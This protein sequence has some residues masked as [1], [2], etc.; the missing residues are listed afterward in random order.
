MHLEV[1]KV[2]LGVHKVHLEV[3]KVLESSESRERER[4]T[5]NKRDER[6]PPVPALASQ[7][8][9]QNQHMS[10]WRERSTGAAGIPMPP[11]CSDG[12]QADT[13]AWRCRTLPTDCSSLSQNHHSTERRAISN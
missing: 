1:H 13:T 7:P 5:S 9:K 11:A 12:P 8:R 3:H 4:T 6:P 10:A 2:H